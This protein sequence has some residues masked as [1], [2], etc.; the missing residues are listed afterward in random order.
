MHPDPRPFPGDTAGRARE[1]RQIRSLNLVSDLA[2]RAHLITVIGDL[3]P[4]AFAT[5]G[6]A[7]PDDLA[8]VL[9]LVRL[10]RPDVVL[11]D[12]TGCEPGVARVVT[13]LA[14]ASAA[15]GVVVVCEQSTAA[16][17]RLGALPKWGWT[18]D[19]RSA[20]ECAAA[21]RSPRAPRAIAQAGPLAGWAEAGHGPAAHRS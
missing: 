1:T 11:L 13:A 19:L 18:Q 20:F 16:A 2:F 21:D 14:D 3:G 17:R 7:K 10:E 15:L 12:A 4:V 6:V 9:A 8:D 5:V